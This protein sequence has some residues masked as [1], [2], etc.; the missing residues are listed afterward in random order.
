MGEVRLIGRTGQDAIAALFFY[1][2]CIENAL[3][4]SGAAKDYSFDWLLDQVRSREMQVWVALPSTM[5]ITQIQVTPL[6]RLLFIFAAVSDD[7]DMGLLEDLREFAKRHRCEVI[8]LCG[9][10]GW[11]RRFPDAEHAALITIEV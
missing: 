8:R 7:L 9:R 11:Y 2:E 5:I 1:R 4:K 10:K 3:E 6:R